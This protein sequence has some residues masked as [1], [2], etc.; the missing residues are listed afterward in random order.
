MSRLDETFAR[1]RA[2]GERGKGAESKGAESKA[3]KAETASKPP[4]GHER[5]RRAMIKLDQ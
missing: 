1:L 2:R 4:P 5:R 3:A